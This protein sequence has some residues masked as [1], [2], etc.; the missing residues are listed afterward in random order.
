MRMSFKRHQSHMILKFSLPILPLRGNE[1]FEA[2]AAWQ[3][4]QTS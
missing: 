4:E 3:A 2:L 1:A